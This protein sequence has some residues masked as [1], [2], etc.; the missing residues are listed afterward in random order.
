MTI[1][2]TSEKKFLTNDSRFKKIFEKLGIFHSLCL[3]DSKIRIDDHDQLYI[4]S[5]L[6]ARCIEYGSN[7]DKLLES[8]VPC[9]DPNYIKTHILD[10]ISKLLN[11]SIK[12]N[13]LLQLLFSGTSRK[14]SR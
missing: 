5:I 7:L 4:L 3:D 9:S 13:F 6:V 11:V 14:S 1:K 12:K 2:D 10:S 8:T